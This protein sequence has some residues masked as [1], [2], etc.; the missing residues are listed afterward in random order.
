M[1]SSLINGQAEFIMC[2]EFAQGSA[3]KLYVKFL[4]NK[5]AKQ[6]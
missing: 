6:Q 3:R 4:L 5:L 1:G 2:I